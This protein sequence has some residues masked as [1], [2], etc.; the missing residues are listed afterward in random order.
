[1]KNIIILAVLLIS[2]T[3]IAQR[4]DRSNREE[5]EN[6]IETLFIAYVTDKLELTTDEAAKFWPIYNEI[7][8]ERRA[9]EKKK[10]ALIN[11]IDDNMQAMSDQQAQ[12]YVNKVIALEKEINLKSFEN[13][14]KEII[15]VI[16]AK[17]FLLL[18]KSEVEFR[19]KMISEFKKKRRR[20]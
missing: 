19:R 4:G 18:K 16:G 12:S 11:E 10:R 5:R 2:T 13:R 7:K 17:R 14:S 8:Q 9:L 6:R 1:M 15:A 20:D 3:A